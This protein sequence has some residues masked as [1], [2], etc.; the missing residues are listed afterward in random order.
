MN[1][2]AITNTDDFIKYVI[3]QLN[4]AKAFYHR[5]LFVI[6]SNDFE[7]SVEYLEKILLAY[8][9]INSNAKGI[10]ILFKEDVDKRGK[11]VKESI[12]KLNSEKNTTYSLK[13]YDFYSS[14][15]LMGRTFD[16]LIIDLTKNLHPDDLGR[17]VET[18]RGGGFIVF[19][20]PNLSE[21][22]SKIL[23]LHKV[24]VSPPF[25]IQDV[26]HRYMLR[27]IKKLFE[28]EGIT[29]FEA[30]TEKFLKKYIPPKDEKPFI[31]SQLEL[32][33]THIFPLEIY[34]LAITQDQVNAV[35]K[36]ETI[37]EY[38]RSKIAV[39]L[40]A[41]RGRGKSVS[42]GLALAGFAYT[43][44]KENNKK[45][46]LLV[47]SPEPENIQPLFEFYIKALEKIGVGKIK[48]EK[49]S[50]G[51]IT[52]VNCDYA[53]LKYLSPLQVTHFSNA[54]ILVVDE[55]AGIPVHILYNYL[56][57][58]Q[59][60]IFSTTIHGYEG[61]G[62]GFSIRFMKR[63]EEDKEVEYVTFSL[64]E[65]IRYAPNDPIEK[66]LFDTLFLDAEPAE[67]DEN[68]LEAINK[69]Q[70]SL[71]EKDLDSW[72]IGKNEQEAKNFI[73]IYVY[74]HYRNRPRDVLILADAPHH[75]AY[76][77][78]LPSRKIVVAIQVAIEGLLPE[79]II[80]SIYR[81]RKDY[82]GQIIPH[83]MIIHQ[84]KPKF[85][86]LKGLRIVR[87]ATHPEVMRKGLGSFALKELIRIAKKEG[88]HYI[89][90]VFGA[91]SELLNFWL[92]N[93]FIPVHVSPDRNPV[94]GEYS[95][96]VIK[97]LTKK[98]HTFVIEANNELRVKILGWLYEQLR[99]MDPYVAALLLHPW[100]NKNRFP[101]KPQLLTITQWERLHGYALELMTYE[102]TSDALRAIF[103]IYFLDGSLEKPK[104]NPKQKALAISKLFQTKDWKR[105]ADT[106]DTGVKWCLIELM[107]IT[108]SLIKFYT[109]PEVWNKLGVR[110]KRAKPQEVKEEDSDKEKN[111]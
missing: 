105:V 100:D 22:A 99:D 31:K 107:H 43:I 95:V 77:L 23:H 32:P 40:T 89:G 42:L 25:T 92:K 50:N 85:A 16:F 9:S 72:F 26:K 4:S 21:W 102:A 7:K 46:N 97:P 54:D 13:I 33:E 49:D 28:H 35:N 61:A 38:K 75:K 55:A 17:L 15:R 73:G 48:T 91:N 1:G 63:L 18:I 36:C 3:Q 81:E 101:N 20:V 103:T 10:L 8:T 44:Y 62:R 104:L 52:S 98:A 68:D 12:R 47:T 110:Y 6:S 76:A 70:A 94:S 64:E 74:A 39:V 2:S 29:I 82:H 14:Q 86:Q 56:K 37:L 34:E 108:R 53:L 93:G 45:A 41:D 83:A 84:R 19:I 59:K 78:H 71:E 79:D 27:F 11:I 87:I 88:Y 51:N 96:V 57:R 30:D 90:A 111:D 67:L 69:L 58:F 24:I 65:P 106:L 109:T 5:R 60:M 80:N 66:W